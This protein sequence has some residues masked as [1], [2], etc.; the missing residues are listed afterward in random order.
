M[1]SLTNTEDHASPSGTSPGSSAETP[2]RSDLETL[3]SPRWETLISDNN[4]GTNK[5][6]I[7]AKEQWS[8]LEKQQLDRYLGTEELMK[9]AALFRLLNHVH[10]AENLKLAAR[11]KNLTAE[12][13]Q[14]KSNNNKMKHGFKLCQMKDYILTNHLSMKVMYSVFRKAPFATSEVS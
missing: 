6:I 4:S 2:S 8:A 11:Q 14:L 12:F 5:I 3:K 1:P 13:A 7:W 10:H 9:I